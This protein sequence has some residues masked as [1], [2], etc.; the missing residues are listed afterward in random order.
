MNPT[1]HPNLSP[2]VSPTVNQLPALSLLL[3][4]LLVAC[5][6]DSAVPDADPSAPPSASAPVSAGDGSPEA[7]DADRT[8]PRLVVDTLD[9]GRFDLA[10][11]R[12]N[13][14][15]VNYWATWCAP[16]IKEIPDLSAFHDS[17]EDAMVIGLAYEEAEPDDLRAFLQR[18]PASYPIALLDVFDPP[19]DFDTPRGL[20][21][22][23][24]I[25]PQGE[26]ARR[27]LGPITSDDLAQAIAAH[28]AGG[29]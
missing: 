21:M 16:C 9:H 27:F 3:P 25:S 12:G 11:Q 19:A 22:T 1:L 10:E 15:V 24:L 2:N 18:V 6:R 8:R 29:G 13:W 14:V 26:V 23:Y 7:G 4:L 5:G 28:G 20:P 17:R